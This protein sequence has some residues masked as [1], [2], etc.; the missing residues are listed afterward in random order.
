[1]RQKKNDSEVLSERA[2]DLET[3]I[4]YFSV[5][6]VFQCEA[7]HD[8]CGG[9]SYTKFKNQRG[10]LM[11]W[12]EKTPEF[13]NKNFK[14]YSTYQ[15][16]FNEVLGIP[17]DL[18]NDILGEYP[19]SGKRIKFNEAL[20][21][22][23][24]EKRWKVISEGQKAY[25]D[26]ET[27]KR[28]VKDSWNRKV[29]PAVPLDWV[30]LFH[31]PRYARLSTIPNASDRAKEIINAWEIANKLFPVVKDNSISIDSI[32]ERLI[33]TARKTFVNRVVTWLNRMMK[34]Q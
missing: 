9:F 16:T 19:E 18:L 29:Y 14:T 7:Y 6:R 1:M 27:N 21:L 15:K 5:T 24:G 34:K 2:R 31:N 3:L 20:D 17:C 30:R 12:N 13:R 32:R 10:W 25:I 28:I 11:Y 23:G 26:K 8:K 4:Y 33:V 22:I